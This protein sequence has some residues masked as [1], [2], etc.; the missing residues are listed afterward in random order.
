[1]SCGM[2]HGKTAGQYISA[3]LPQNFV[4]QTPVFERKVKRPNQVL[5]RG[6][7]IRP[8]KRKKAR[9]L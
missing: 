7:I 2:S 3:K 1:M 5:G 8:D 9:Y 6:G 4:N